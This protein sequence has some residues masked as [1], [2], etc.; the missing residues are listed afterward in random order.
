MYLDIQATEPNHK[1]LPHEIPARQWKTVGAVIFSL[2][3]KHYLHTIAY[4]V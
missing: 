1:N 3:S 4:H 2:N